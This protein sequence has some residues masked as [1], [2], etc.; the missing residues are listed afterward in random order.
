M[1]QYY[2]VSVNYPSDWYFADNNFELE[3]KIEKLNSK[4]NSGAGMTI[5]SSKR[6]VHFC[7]LTRPAAEKLM[8][9]AR[10]L[11]KGITAVLRSQKERY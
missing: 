3:L 4:A 11:R 10:K 2:S 9:R 7:N 8:L 1:I 5:G 6:E